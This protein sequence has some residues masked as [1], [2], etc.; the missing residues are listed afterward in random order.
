M[1]AQLSIFRLFEF[2]KVPDA[3]IPE[4]I[5]LKR[6]ELWCPYCSNRV[7]FMRDKSA[8]VRK[9]PICGISDRDFWVKKVNKLL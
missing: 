1:D 8:G 5:K 2:N 7:I 3:E 6:G 4:N 9:C